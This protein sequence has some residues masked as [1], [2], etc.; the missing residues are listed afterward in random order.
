MNTP[1]IYSWIKQEENKFETQEIQLADNWYWNFRNHVQLIFHLKNGIFMQG[2]ND[3]T[4]AFK[5]IMEPLLNLAYWTE[6]IE[7]KDVNF[8]IEGSNGKALSFLIKKYHDEIYVRENNIDE[9][10]DEIAESDIDYGGTLV[11]KGVKIPEVL[12]LNSIAFC[13]QNDILSAPIGFKMYL[14][15]D[16]LRSMGKYGWG[17]ESN[18]ATISLDDLCV[19]A[20]QETEIPGNNGKKN[21]RSGKVVEIYFVRGNMPSHF[22]NDDDNMET[23]FNQ[24]HIVAF[25]TNKEGNKTGV[26]LYRKEE[27]E[28]NLKFHT[29]KKVYQ[30]AL[31]RG[32]GETFLG[33]QIWTNFLTIHK[34]NLLEAASKVPLQTDDDSFTDRNAIQDMENLQVMTLADGKSVRPIQTASPVNINLMEGAIN[35]WFEHAQYAGSA[36]DPIMGKE[37]SSG[38]TFRGQERS[39]AQGKGLHERRRGQRAKFIEEIYR[40]YIIPDIK[41]EILKGK[42]F[43]AELTPDELNWVA[44]Q[45]AIVDS[46]KIIV[47]AILKNGKAI[48]E[49]EQNALIEIRKQS[50]MKQ[51]NRQLIEILEDEFDGVEIKMGINIAGK[52]KDLLGLSDKLLSIFQFIIANPQGFQSAMQIPALAKA[53]ENILEYGGMSIADFSTLVTKM[54]A[55]PM[56]QEQSTQQSP[57]LLPSNA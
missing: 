21:E 15:P 39:V 6:D 34:T 3:W 40:D 4:R 52:Q 51:G 41:K 23:E 38:T 54:P 29:T 42:K 33:P 35:E 13:D 45:M 25:Y 22:L 24:L 20:T 56:M 5:N 44:E 17:K 57:E 28:G 16:K 9:L 53:F 47:D 30:R 10:F 8:F 43:L 37:S 2:A 19:L 12:Q 14:S 32:A 49:E 1:N 31:G 48:T 18:G 26:T 7:V 55:Q 27:S 11:Q 46:N 50:I 36:F